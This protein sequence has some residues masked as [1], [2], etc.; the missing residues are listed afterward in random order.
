MVGG[1][2]DTWLHCSGL[3]H[4]SKNACERAGTY[5][6]RLVHQVLAEFEV[7]CAGAGSPNSQIHT[8]MND[9]TPPSHGY[10]HPVQCTHSRQLEVSRCPNCPLI[11]AAKYAPLWK[12]Q[13][14][15]QVIR[16]GSPH[17]PSS[18]RCSAKTATRHVAALRCVWDVSFHSRYQ[19]AM[20]RQDL[21]TGGKVGKVLVD[22]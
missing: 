3:Y 15:L 13:R 2:H 22:C 11:H 12:G 21:R 18:G 7:G 14:S 9:H 1:A 10:S 20:H 17:I 4:C 16:L 8:F 6:C 19:A 5:L